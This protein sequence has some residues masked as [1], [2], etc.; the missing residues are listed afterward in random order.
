[1]IQRIQSVWLLLAALVMA[2]LFVTNVYSVAIP[3][4]LSA[5]V[6]ADYMKIIS[7]NNNFLALGLAGASVIMSVVSIFLF[8]MRKQ[9]K[10]LI[11]INILLTIGLLFW[12]YIGLNSFWN[13]YPAS[14]GNISIGLFLPV[15]SNFFLIFALR[16]IRKDEKLLKSLDRL[17]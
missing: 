16:G 11:W 14:G 8:K 4:G 7:I 2:G 15:I 12:L 1:M 5:E 10:S 6:Q 13:T 9:Q 3:T 17:R